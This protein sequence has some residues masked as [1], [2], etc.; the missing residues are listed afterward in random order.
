[1]SLSAEETAELNE[2]LSI[3]HLMRLA[4][5]RARQRLADQFQTTCRATVTLAQQLQTGQVKAPSADLLALAK[6]AAEHCAS[7]K[8]ED[9]Q[10]WAER[11]ARDTGN[12]T[13]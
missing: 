6:Q 10:I 7:R 8:D 13:D 11:L 12:A 1:M 3:E 5:E 2:Y 4:R 9:I